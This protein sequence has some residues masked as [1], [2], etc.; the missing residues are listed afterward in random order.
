M[1]KRFVPRKD[2][3]DLLDAE[4]MQSFIHKILTHVEES[5]TH[6]Y[7]NPNLEKLGHEILRTAFEFGL[8]NLNGGCPGCGS[9]CHTS[10]EPP[11][12][13]DNPKPAKSPENGKI[14]PFKKLN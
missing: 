4:T 12:E 9:S 3:V 8:V 1:T 14:I 7:Y 11:E 5:Q 10:D 6:P 2:L 13:T